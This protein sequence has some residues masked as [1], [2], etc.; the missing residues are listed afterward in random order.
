V[1]EMAPAPANPNQ[2]A[3]ADIESAIQ[4]VLARG[5]FDWGP[6]VPAFEQEFAEWSGSAY[7]VGANSGLAALKLALKAA[8]IGPGD[9]VIT[10]PNSDIATTSAI[11]QVGARAIW[12]DVEPDT[13][14]MDPSLVEAAITPRTRALL[15]V[16]LYGHPAD[17]VALSAIARRHN[18]FVIEDACLSVGASIEGRPVGSWGDITCVS[19]APTK[20]LGALGSAGT[21]LTH[22]PDLAERMLLYAGYGQRRDRASRR[23]LV[24]QPQD[25]LVEGFN[26]RL[27]ELQAAVLRAKLPYVAGWIRLRRANAHAYHDA[28]RD[29][30]IVLPLERPAYHHTYRQ[31]VIRVGDRER[32]Q[33]YLAGAGIATALTYVP[34]LHLQ[35]AYHSLNYPRGSF[36]VTEAACDT[37]LSIPVAPELT[38]IQRD[39]IISVLQDIYR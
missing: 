24:G 20:H 15:P 29:T 30:G 2:V 25:Y 7:A 23:S 33:T 13:M 37:L 34:P 12:V 21:A 10:V 38:S 5:E 22:D 35:P 28:L 6:E 18:L 27:D 26:E 8:G 39:T 3:R 19:H 17:M 31:Y 4:R 14:N 1:A 16:H 32:I 9:E 36:P 11:H